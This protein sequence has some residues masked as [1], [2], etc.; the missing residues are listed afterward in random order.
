[1]QVSAA[2]FIAVICA[3][4]TLLASCAAY[5]VAVTIK[6]SSLNRSID[7]SAEQVNALRAEIS[8][9]QEIVKANKSVISNDAPNAIS[10]KRTYVA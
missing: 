9:L 4:A 8:A 5:A 1:M 7:E 10:Y 6:V 3:L 2:E